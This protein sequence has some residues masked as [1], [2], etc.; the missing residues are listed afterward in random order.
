MTIR[1]CSTDKHLQFT[2]YLCALGFTLQRDFLP[3]LV[4]RAMKTQM[5]LRCHDREADSTSFPI[6]FTIWVATFLGG[7][8]PFFSGRKYKPRTSL[9]SSELHPD[10]FNESEKFVF[11]REKL[12]IK[13]RSHLT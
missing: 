10:F 1:I 5:Q 11:F 3:F 8:R 6:L 12:V 9:T 7:F 4:N 2:I 13:N